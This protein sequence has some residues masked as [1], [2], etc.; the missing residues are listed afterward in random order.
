[1]ADVKVENLS[2]IDLTGNVAQYVT[3]CPNCSRLGKRNDDYKLSVSLEKNVYHCYRCG[4]SGKATSLLR[5]YV[6][7]GDL[8]RYRINFDNNEFQRNP[9]NIV[10]SELIDYDNISQPID[11]MMLNAYSYLKQRNISLDEINK[12]NIRIGKGLYKGRILVPTYDK[13]GNI[14]YLTAREYVDKNV[15]NK[16]L[17]PPGSHKAL[18]VWN[19]QNIK[20]CD[21]VVVT[22]G[23][24]SG[25]AANRVLKGKAKS[26]AIFGKSISDFQAKMI[27]E[28][29]PK[30]IVLSFDGD[31]SK[32]GILSNFSEIRKYFPGNITILK[33]S[34]EED[35]DSIDP[36][37][38]RKKF[39][40][41]MSAMKFK[42]T[43]KFLE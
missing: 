26:V 27:S 24:F 25:I 36:S 13:V 6:N 8:I 31:V 37:L 2:D 21:I 4:S 20:P 33:L 38:Y 16:Y 9:N 35:P 28:T 32:K 34:G 39:E 23:V 30:E 15:E 14:V 19:I 41:R 40:D 22:E 17:N 1:M 11:R 42:I 29:N 12:Y 3:H 5:G 7:S 43:G 10:S 18:A